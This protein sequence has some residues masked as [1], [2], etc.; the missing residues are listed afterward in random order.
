MMQSKIISTQLRTTVTNLRT[1]LVGGSRLIKL[2]PV[3][4]TSAFTVAP[5]F[6]YTTKASQTPE[7]QL[8]EVLKSELKISNTIPNELD[9]IYSDYLNKSGF[10]VEETSGNSNVQLIKEANGEIVRVFFDIDEVTD[11][12]IQDEMAEQEDLN[13]EVDSL[14]SMLC[15]V[16][17]LIENSTTG[18]GLLLNLF[19]QNS[20]SSFLIDFAV[21]KPEV[22]A[23]L[24]NQVTRGEFLDKFQYQGP[25]FSDLDE[26]LQATFESYLD[27]KGINNELA[28]FIISFSEFK[29]E[30]EYRKWLGD[31]AGFLD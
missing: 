3:F 25:R 12:P 20:E 22:N 26:S 31:L 15:N 7:N 24:D 5:R 16:K 2:S 23:Y 14:E 27:S 4:A 19:L 10:T 1:R 28:E 18:N 17:I 9:S 8:K 6:A 21:Y 11:I 29:E 30:K 13:E